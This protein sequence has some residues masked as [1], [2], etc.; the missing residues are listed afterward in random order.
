MKYTALTVGPI[1]KTL[2]RVKRTRAVWA[3]SYFYSWVI[4]KIVMKSIEE[5]LNIILPDDSELHKNKYGA[6]LYADRIY[7]SDDVKNKLK[8][9]IKDTFSEITKGINN[10]TGF[11]TNESLQYLNDYIN[12]HV[13][14]KE[15]DNE[16]DVLKT[17]NDA[18]D[19]AELQVHYPFAD[20]NSPL[21]DY[22]D[23]RLANNSAI[24]QDAFNSANQKRFLSIPEIATKDIQRKFSD[25]YDAVVKMLEQGHIAENPQ[26]NAEHTPIDEDLDFIDKL[27]EQVGKDHI[28]P[29]HK[30][31]A[32]LSADG[33]NIGA[34]LKE[35]SGDFN[36]LKK[37]SKQLFEFGKK[38][39]EVIHHYGG[40]G[41]YLGGED[42]LAFLPIACKS[43][44]VNED[45]SNETN[46][47]FSLIK[48][49]DRTFYE[50]LGNYAENLG[51]EAPTLSYGLMIAYNKN[52]LKESRTM[53]YEL[54][55]R[56]KKKTCKNTLSLR[57]QKHSGQ[58]F[59]CSIEKTKTCSW[60]AILEIVEKYTK[61][62]SDRNEDILS[63]VI[64]RIKDD[65]FFTAFI[66]ASKLG[67]LQGF[68]SNSFDEDIHKSGPKALFLK[69]FVSFSEKIVNDYPK[70][71]NVRDII[72]TVLR[73]IHFINA[74]K[75]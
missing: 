10:V 15:I 27:I 49:L 60:N 32:I 1:Y 14:V 63:G 39:E 56:S 18:L 48:E 72:F 8:R 13:I 53:A 50:T 73:F 62:I 74:K 69:D 21:L 33:D 40:S 7:Y 12:I 17:L 9:I 43:E 5:K 45:K 75:D 70:E 59:K 67:M 54:L 25:D 38:A 4:K 26:H 20:E 58:Y 65:L 46:T 22:L 52:P 47:I 23:S 16:K 6:G 29:F 44:T 34:I 57:F 37:F 66:Q 19:Q 42:I 64:H 28:R 51:V 55:K 31:I 35:I 61:N 30:Y 71:K 3:A 68:I 36:E 24:V 11:D 2:D 41:V